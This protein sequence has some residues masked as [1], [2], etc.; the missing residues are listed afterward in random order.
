MPVTAIAA[1]A[2]FGVLFTLWVIL[3]SRLRKRHENTDNE[4]E[5]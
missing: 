1:A 5:E 2:S 4:V 3:P